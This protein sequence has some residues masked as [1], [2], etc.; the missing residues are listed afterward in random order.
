MVRQG[1]RRERIGLS[2]FFIL[3]SG[4]ILMMFAYVDI[5][6]ES[7]KPSYCCSSGRNRLGNS[8]YLASQET[9]AGD[10]PTERSE[11]GFSDQI[12]VQEYVDPARY[13]EQMG[14]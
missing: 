8:G 7:T 5:I 12:Y 4:F 10:S 3:Y 1:I 6:E 14:G 13:E 9:A 11:T 2:L